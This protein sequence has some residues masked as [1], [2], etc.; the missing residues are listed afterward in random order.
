M[1]FKRY[2]I[3]YEK[4]VLH[5]GVVWMVWEKIEDELLAHSPRF[6]III[7]SDQSW[8]GFTTTA[9]SDVTHAKWFDTIEQVKEEL[10]ILLL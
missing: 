7:A 6:K 8:V 9:F 2:R 10:A 4:G 3:Y 1:N 5:P